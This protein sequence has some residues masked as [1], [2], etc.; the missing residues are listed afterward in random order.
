MDRIWRASL[1]VKSFPVMQRP[2]LIYPRSTINQAQSMVLIAILC[3]KYT[4]YKNLKIKFLRHQGIGSRGFHSSWNLFYQD[5]SNI[6]TICNLYSEIFIYFPL[7][8]PV[9]HG[10]IPHLISIEYD[11]A[12]SWVHV[13]FNLWTPTS[14]SCIV[15]GP[16]SEQ[17]L[18][19]PCLCCVVGQ[20]VYQFPSAEMSRWCLCNRD[21]MLSLA[22]DK[23]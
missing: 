21:Y 12:P 3:K 5:Y 9:R 18:L 4:Y 15:P 11:I 23:Q 14:Q 10:A 13:F 19:R 20:G 1:M 6:L 22:I 8:S 16:D 7:Q 2:W 17:M